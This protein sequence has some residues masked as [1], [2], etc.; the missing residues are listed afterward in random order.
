MDSI[1]KPNAYKEITKVVQEVKLSAIVKDIRSM[2]DNELDKLGESFSQLFCGIADD[3]INAFDEIKTDIKNE[4][5]KHSF[6]H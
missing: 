1:P 5:V 4:L 2:D 3:C 6:W